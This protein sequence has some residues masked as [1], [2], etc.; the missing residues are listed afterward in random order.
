MCTSS[1]ELIFF[2]LVNKVKLHYSMVLHRKTLTQ[3]FKTELLRYFHPY[4]NSFAGPWTHERK[5]K[6]TEDKRKERSQR[7][8]VGWK[9]IEDTSWV[10][11][12][13][14]PQEVEWPVYATIEVMQ[15][16]V[17]TPVFRGYWGP[18]PWCAHPGEKSKRVPA[19]CRTAWMTWLVGFYYNCLPTPSPCNWHFTVR[20][21]TGNQ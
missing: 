3:Q 12:R 14:F 1:A 10:Q 5:R 16:W 4:L 6:E 20:D 13:D 8:R 2:Y 18:L 11:F 15:F 17:D 7:K 9:E 19:A 21:N